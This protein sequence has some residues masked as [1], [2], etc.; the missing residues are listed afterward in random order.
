[1]LLSPGVAIERGRKKKKPEMTAFFG[2]EHW[3]DLT[4]SSQKCQK[5][6]APPYPTLSSFCFFVLVRGCGF[7]GS[8]GGVYIPFG[9]V[10][11]VSGGRGE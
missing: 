9:E 4:K 10:G 8:F 11:R 2:G 5:F 1:V 7:F 6:W 3:V